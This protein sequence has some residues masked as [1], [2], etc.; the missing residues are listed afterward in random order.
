MGHA[1]VNYEHLKEEYRKVLRENR[2]HLVTITK[3]EDEKRALGA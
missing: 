3:L 1:E 2:D